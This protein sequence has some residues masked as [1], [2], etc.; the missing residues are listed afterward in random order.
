M[1]NIAALDHQLGD[2]E[3]ARHGYS[4]SLVLARD[5]GD[6]L[7]LV[8]SLLGMASIASMRSQDRAL[9]IRW[10]AV[11]SASLEA[12]GATL[13]PYEQTLYDEALARVQPPLASAAWAAAWQAGRALPLHTSVA[14]ALGEESFSDWA[15]PTPGQP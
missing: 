2:L 12:L 8:Y 15:A 6:R 11:V 1:I 3:Q 9:A 4:Q 14:L 5:I 10:L 13:E 7:S